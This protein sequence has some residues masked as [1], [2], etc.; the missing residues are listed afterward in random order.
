MCFNFEK[1]YLQSWCCVL[2]HMFQT[3]VFL[4]EQHSWLLTNIM[5]AWSTA[6]TFP[7]IT[8][9]YNRDKVLQHKSTLRHFLLHFH[10]V[11]VSKHKID[12]VLHVLYLLF[13]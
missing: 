7:A 11:F 12:C 6:K 3:W 13:V 10:P 5:T 9:S 4:K 8:F 2:M 1:V